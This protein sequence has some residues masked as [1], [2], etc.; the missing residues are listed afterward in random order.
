MNLLSLLNSNTFPQTGLTWLTNKLSTGVLDR[1]KCSQTCCITSD[2]GLL[3]DTDNFGKLTHLTTFEIIVIFLIYV[4]N[5][6]FS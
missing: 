1:A 5:C 4:V 6:I 2:D 3:P